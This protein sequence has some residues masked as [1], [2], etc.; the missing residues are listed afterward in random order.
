[1]V[2]SRDAG[3]LSW[4]ILGLGETAHDMSRD[5]THSSRS[6]LAGAAARDP[7]RVHRFAARMPGVRAYASYLDLVN[8]DDIDVVYIASIHPLHRDLALQALD[9]GKHVLV[10]KPLGLNASQARDIAAAAR[11]LGRFCME[12]MWMRFNPLVTRVV[13]EIAEGRIG[14]VETVH[15]DLSYAFKYDPAHRVFNL[16]LGGG[17]LLDLG[18]YPAHFAWLLLG[19]PED[20]EASCVRAPSG[21]DAA[22]S[23]TWHYSTGQVAHLT[24]SLQRAVPSTATVVGSKGTVTLHAPMQAPA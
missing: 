18:I 1:M 8:D 7:A 24:C 4:G 14:D 13:N 16:E 21:V 15:A 17:A 3:R 20:V 2:R 6:L 10:E 23:M 11:G 19:P 9:A 12:A 22:A 5:L